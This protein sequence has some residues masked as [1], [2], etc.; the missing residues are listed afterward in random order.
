M[1]DMKPYIGRLLSRHNME[2]SIVLLMSGEIKELKKRFVTWC[3]TWDLN[4]H[5]SDPESIG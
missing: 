1:E 3:H 4:L 2:T 5:Y